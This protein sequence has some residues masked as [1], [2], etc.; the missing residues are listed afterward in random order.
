MK[1]EFS[2]FLIEFKLLKIIK[3]DDPILEI[4][5]QRLDD[6]GVEAGHASWEASIDLIVESLDLSS[7][8][9]DYTSFD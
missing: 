3:D 1:K 4:M 2:N 5:L 9:E 7:V 6:A 8:M